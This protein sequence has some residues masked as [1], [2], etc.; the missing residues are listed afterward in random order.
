MNNPQ[1]ILC[2]EQ[3][4]YC[5]KIIVIKRT[6]ICLFIHPSKFYIIYDT[7]I[8]FPRS[9]QNHAG[10]KVGLLFIFNIIKFYVSSLIT[11]MNK[12]F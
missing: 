11:L 10:F 6:S 9:L 12:H 1:L 4:K 8:L 5:L 3:Q 7:V 2:L